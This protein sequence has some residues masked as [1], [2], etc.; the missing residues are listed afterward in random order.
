M[1]PSEKPSPGLARRMKHA[2]RVARTHAYAPYSGFRVGAAV[3]AGDGRVFS[4]SNVENASYG[5]TVCAERNAVFRAVGAGAKAITAVVI[6]AGAGEPAPPCGACRQVLS[7]FGV[8][9]PVISYSVGGRV[10]RTNI[11]ELL[12]HPFGGEQLRRKRSSRRSNT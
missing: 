1:T 9:V 3:L 2:A 11:L 8:D 5:L 6:V 10:L 12:P 7:E 4:G